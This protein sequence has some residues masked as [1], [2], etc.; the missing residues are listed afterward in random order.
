MVTA[1]P[2]TPATIARAGTAPKASFSGVVRSEVTK[3]RSVTST[4]VMLLLMVVIGVGI[5][6]LICV[7]VAA[8]TTAN[9]TDPTAV[10]LAGLGLGQLIATI[11]GVM[12]VT[13]EYTSGTIRLSLM[14]VPRRVQFALAKMLVIGVSTLVVG[15]VIAFAAFLIGQPILRG[16]HPNSAGVVAWA[17]FGQTG[18]LRAVIGAGLFLTLLALLGA[19]LGLLVRSTAASIAIVVAMLFIVPIIFALLPSNIGHPLT[20]WWPTSAGGN[21]I[22]VHPA[23]TYSLHPWPGF[24]LMCGFVAIVIVAAVIVLQR[25]DA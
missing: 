19:A 25:R 7:A 12:V 20:K 15:E 13:S 6:A 23:N 8:S 24:A 18:V 5:G 9:D 10:S 2:A 22:R 21:I 4:Y 17:S 16:G 1:T 3:L 11:F 14:A